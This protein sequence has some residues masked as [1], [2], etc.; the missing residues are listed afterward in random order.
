MKNLF[1]AAFA[2]SFLCAGPALAF[3]AKDVAGAWAS[4]S[5]PDA[6]AKAPI[7]LFMSDGSL[8]IFESAAGGLHA[9]GVWKLDGATLHMTHNETPLAMDGKASEPVDLTL[10]E[11][12]A[13][14]FVS[15]NAKGQERARTRCKDLTLPAGAVRQAH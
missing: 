10:V 7:S 5:G 8:A 6:C 9:I 3:E 11:L 14:K 12:T 2:V 1:A 13:E 15:K 4:G